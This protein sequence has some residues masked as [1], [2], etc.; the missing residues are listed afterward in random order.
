[1]AIER[2]PRG[3]ESRSTKRSSR[4]VGRQIEVHNSAP[5]RFDLV[6]QQRRRRVDQAA[7]DA[8]L[9]DDELALLLK[10]MTFEIC[11]GERHR[12]DRLTVEACAKVVA[13]GH[14]KAAVGRP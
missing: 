5:G 13:P 3:R 7:L 2:E 9:G 14:V 12:L 10:K 6:T 8:V 1:M 11:K 4:P